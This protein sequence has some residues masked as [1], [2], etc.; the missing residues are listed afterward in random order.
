MPCQLAWYN[1]LSH[2]VPCVMQCNFVVL[3]YFLWLW[4]YIYYKNSYFE[5]GLRRLLWC[6]NALTSCS[7]KA[8]SCVTDEP[9]NSTGYTKWFDGEPEG[10][11][12]QDCGIVNRE[13]SA[14]GDVLCG[15]QLPFFCEQ[16]LWGIAWQ[17]VGL[18][19]RILPMF[20]RNILTP[21][22]GSEWSWT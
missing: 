18:S 9:L 17:R 12:G 16:E 4:F 5:R 22:S 7:L 15:V 21:Y 20:L 2:F 8:V 10:K 6:R 14:L 3:L 13:S 11:R 19:S 1:V